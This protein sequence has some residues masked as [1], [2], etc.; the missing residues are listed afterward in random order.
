MKKSELR[1]LIREEIKEAIYAMDF[2]KGGM[3]ELGDDKMVILPNS[4]YYIGAS[5]SPDHIVVTKVDDRMIHYYKYPYKKELRIEKPIGMDLIR[6]GVTTWLKS[7]YKKYHPE[8]ARSLQANLD[9]KKG[10]QN[11]KAKLQDYQ[12]VEVEIVGNPGED[13]YGIGKDYGVV[14]GDWDE[15]ENKVTVSL[16]RQ[17]IPELK[18]DKRIKSVK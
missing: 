2:G 1:K 6:Q 12:Y 7:G 10:S 16:M 17:Y 15:K 8:L 5:S 4:E 18:R 11:G 9:G 3:R 13:V 14:K